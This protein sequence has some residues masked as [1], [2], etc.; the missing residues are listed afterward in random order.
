MHQHPDTTALFRS[1]LEADGGEA[2]DP[3]SPAARASLERILAAAPLRR[4]PPVA[5]AVP[6]C[7]ASRLR[8]RRRALC[9]QR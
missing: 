4:Y 7:S 2:F 5:T 9:L 8:E 3:D 1:L 6:R